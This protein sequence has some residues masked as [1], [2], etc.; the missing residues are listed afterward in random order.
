V[1]DEVDRVVLFVL[2]KYVDKVNMADEVDRA[3]DD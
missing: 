1:V 3:D 2:F